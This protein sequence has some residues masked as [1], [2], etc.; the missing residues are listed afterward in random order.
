MSSQAPPPEPPSILYRTF[1]TIEELSAPDAESLHSRSGLRGFIALQI[2][3][4]GVIPNISQNFANRELVKYPLVQLLRDGPDGPEPRHDTPFENGVCRVPASHIEIGAFVKEEVDLVDEAHLANPS[5]KLQF[6]QNA[7]PLQRFFESFMSSMATLGTQEQLKQY[8]VPEAAVDIV[9]KADKRDIFVKELLSGMDHCG[10]LSFFQD[11]MPK[12]KEI[13]AKCIH[14]DSMASAAKF[15]KDGTY[16]YLLMYYDEKNDGNNGIYVG[17][18]HSPWAR[19]RQHSDCLS[20]DHPALHYHMG[21]RRLRK[22]ARHRLFPIAFLPKTMP[23]SNLFRSWGETILVV[24]FESFNPLMLHKAGSPMLASD[25]IP[26]WGQSLE[27]DSL[28]QICGSPLANMLR[29]VASGIKSAEAS[30]TKLCLQD[31]ATGFNWSVPLVEGIVNEASLWI[32]TTTPGDVS[33]ASPAMWTFRTHPRRVM[34]DKRIGVLG[35]FGNDTQPP[36]F[37]PFIPFEGTNLGPGSLVNIVIEITIDPGTRHPSPFVQLPKFGPFDYWEEAFRIVMRIEFEEG[38]IWKTRYLK[39]E[40]LTT[41]GAKIKSMKASDFGE[42]LNHLELGW[43]HCIKAIAALLNWRWQP[44]D[45]ALAQRVWV[46]YCCRLRL[47][48]FDF[49][50]QNLLVS[51]AEP[52]IKQHPLPLTLDETADLIEDN[53]GPDVHIG[54]LPDNVLI[55]TPGVGVRHKCD[56]CWVAGTS[57]LVPKQC[58]TQRR[59][60][61]T[62]NGVD[63]V[64]CP[65]SA[66]M[67]R[68]CTFTERIETREDLRDLVYRRPVNYEVKIIEPPPNVFQYLEMREKLNEEAVPAGDDGDDGD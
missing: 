43:L 47:I 10:T 24:L 26:Q 30:L 19:Y 49:F 53:F 51:D 32:R 31:H 63:L 33:T 38:G 59:V 67:G 16:Y 45:N 29:S 39:Q 13:W 15:N 12:L 44:S 8:G 21:R 37:R 1:R 68:Y 5:L 35:G 34:V 56:L 3:D 36:K 22:G 66:A 9:G 27:R 41:F 7:S 11:G 54:C 52:A 57:V 42:E 50:K 18:T 17:R 48:E 40:S 6:Q 46:P 58:K 60:V 25:D 64:Q 65:L 61:K 20:K 28:L 14:V 55:Q 2:G 4:F 23:N 62:I